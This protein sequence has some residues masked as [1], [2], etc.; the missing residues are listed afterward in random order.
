[1]EYLQDFAIKNLAGTSGTHLPCVR[2]YG[3]DR[4]RR[5]SASGHPECEE[6]DTCEPQ[7]EHH[8]I[9]QMDRQRFSDRPR[10]A[11]AIGPFESQWQVEQYAKK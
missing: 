4:P 9:D 6:D 3:L 2:G 8:N 10:E 1:M 7:P 11:R 5:G